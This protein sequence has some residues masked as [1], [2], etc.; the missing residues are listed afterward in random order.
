[1]FTGIVDCTSPVASLTCS[2]GVGRLEVELPDRP[3][4]SDLEVGES[5]AVSGVCLT[6]VSGDGTLRFDVVEETLRRTNLGELE[7]GSLVNLERALRVGDRLGGH[8]VQGHVDT[9][10]EIISWKDDAGEVLVRIRIQEPERVRVVPKGSVTVDGISLTVVDPHSAEFSIALIPHT[11]EI[12]SL[13]QRGEGD[14]VNLEMD[15][16]GKWVEQL[17]S[18]RT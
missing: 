7:T 4:W 11:L 6:L 13:G 2:D 5:I 10:G 14:I 15:H 1:M 12:T 18:D 8:Y 16:F 17:M 3:G 9:T